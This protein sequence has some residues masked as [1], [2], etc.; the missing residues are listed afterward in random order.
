M[1]GGDPVV[2]EMAL[3]DPPH[4]DHLAEL[5]AGADQ[6]ALSLVETVRAREAEN[7]A[8][9]ARAEKAE[10][11]VAASRA[12]LREC[13]PKCDGCGARCAPFYAGFMYGGSVVYGAW[14]GDCPA[15]DP[16]AEAEHADALRA[17]TVA[18]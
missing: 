17:A 18:P 4:A 16:G 8:L 10:R 3:L 14:C 7:A 11:E 5:F 12:A 6:D 15:I 2:A 13:A 9:L 1:A